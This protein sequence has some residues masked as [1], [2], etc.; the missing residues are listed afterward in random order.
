MFAGAPERIACR[1]ARSGV[2]DFMRAVAIVLVVFG[3][4]QRGL[5][6]SGETSGAYWNSV[7]PVVDYFI[8]VFHVPIFFATSGVL[9]ERYSGQTPRQ[10]AAR[11][12]RLVLLYGFWNTINALPAVFFAGY[13]NRSFGQAGYLDAINPLHVNGIMWFFVALMFAQTAHFLTR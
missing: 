10:F 7:Y 11:A 4:V 6:Q 13:I 8:Y 9:L 1:P 2:I 12:G 3:H 5:V